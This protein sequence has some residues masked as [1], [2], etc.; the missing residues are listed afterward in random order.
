MKACRLRLRCTA[1]GPAFPARRL[2]GRTLACYVPHHNF[3]QIEGEE[4]DAL[5]SDFRN[6]RR[7][8]RERARMRRAAGERPAISLAADQD[9]RADRARRRR[10]HR[11]ARVCAEARRE[12]QDHRGR[13]PDRRRRHDR[14]RLRRQVA[15]R[16]LHGLCRISRDAV[17]PAA[18]DE[19]SLRRRQGFQPGH[20]GRALAQYPGRA[21]L[22]SR[23]VAERAD[24]LRQG[25]S[26][27]S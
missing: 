18:P 22:R 10:R 5:I 25:Q 3:E 27:A 11:R 12:R 1:A 16:R 17:D 8:V 6:R 4:H 9:H 14:G 23:A 13:E 24:R 15:A 20:P 21:S 19:A 7:A 2:H 26:R